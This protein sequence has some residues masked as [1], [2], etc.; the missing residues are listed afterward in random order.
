MATPERFRETIPSDLQE[1]E[2]VQERI[3]SLLE[4]MEFG[5]RDVFGMRL[6]LEEAIVNAIK[7][8]NGM[9]PSKSVEILCEI[10]DER[11]LVVITDEGPG[12]DPKD[13]P[14][15]TDDDNLEKPGGRGIMLMKA[16]MTRVEYNERG[17]TVT[18]EKLR[19]NGEES[20]D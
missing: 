17:N 18:L 1:A 12:F 8:G 7:H 3:I 14:D 10:G 6:A 2:R 20:E 15:P 11:A 9:D 4:T 13:I 16:F 19:E 5:A